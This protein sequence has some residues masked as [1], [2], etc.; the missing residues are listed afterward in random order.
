[1]I[2]Q[3]VSPGRPGSHVQGTRAWMSSRKMA[4]S[5]FP[6]NGCL[7]V[8]DVYDETSYRQ[9]KFRGRWGTAPEHGAR[10]LPFP[11]EPGLNSY[12]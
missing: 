3:A 8:A 11:L 5:R 2:R 4:R 6:R 12:R 1:M 7:G 9:P 10:T